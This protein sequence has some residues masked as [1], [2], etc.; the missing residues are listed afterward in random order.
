MNTSELMARSTRRAVA[1]V[2][3]ETRRV[4]QRCTTNEYGDLLAREPGTRRTTSR[5]GVR[6]T[7][8][9][10]WTKYGPNKRVIRI[11]DD[12]LDAAITALTAAKT[13]AKTT[14][15]YARARRREEAAAAAEKAARQ[16]RAA[17]EAANERARL[18][19]LGCSPDWIATLMTTQAGRILRNAG[20]ELYDGTDNTEALRAVQY[21]ADTESGAWRAYIS[22][23]MSA[24]TLVRCMVGAGRRHATDY[25]YIVTELRCAGWSRD[26]ARD[27]ARDRV[28]YEC[29]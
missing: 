19:D 29:R 25:D 26:E 23:E 7:I 24:A 12:G 27:E 15:A 22:G 11:T 18:T 21:A 28:R 1:R 10:D 16:E 9:H 13:A 4:R 6:F 3:R 20:C 8:V 17:A 2:Q 14:R 5:H